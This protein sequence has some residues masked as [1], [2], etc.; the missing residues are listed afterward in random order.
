LRQKATRRKPSVNVDK[1]NNALIIHASREDI[2]RMI[3]LV[4]KL[5]RPTPQVLIEAYIIEATRETA[6]ELG[7]QW[8]GLTYAPRGSANYWVRGGDGTLTGITGNTNIGTPGN[9]LFTAGGAAQRAN[10]S[11][12][13]GAYFPI[14][15]ARDLR[16]LGS[17]FSVGFLAEKVGNFVLSTQLSALESESKLNILSS[18]SIT[19]V[20]NQ[21]AMIES[22][23]EVPFQTTTGAGAEREVEIE[24]KKAVLKLEVTP[25]VVDDKLLKLKIVTTKDDLDFTRT[26]L[27]NPTI[28]TKRADTTVMLLDGQTVVIGGLSQGTDRGS[29]TGLPWIKDIPFLGYIFKAEGKGNVMDEVLIFITPHIL[30][31]KKVAVRNQKDRN[32]SGKTPQKKTK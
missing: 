3:A 19:T 7:I 29:E 17:S 20:D 15:V 21:T 31:Q 22:G 2:S 10:P 25:H 27:G 6:R 1:H 12:G 18:P 26:V 30:K 32:P 16:G 5:D 23:R 28:I 4:E 9:Q 14:D 11:S 13:L 24:W 8:G